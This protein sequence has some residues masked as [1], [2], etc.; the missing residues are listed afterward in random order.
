[1][2]PAATSPASKSPARSSS[3][4]AN[5]SSAAKTTKPPRRLGEASLQRAPAPVDERRRQIP[6][7]DRRR[8]D[9]REMPHQPPPETQRSRQPARV[10]VSERGE[11]PARR[12]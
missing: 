9:A 3:E 4:T 1:M 11:Q 6:P 10:H 2:C 12:Q 7:H 8:L 5:P